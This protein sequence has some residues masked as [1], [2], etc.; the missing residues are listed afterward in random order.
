MTQF[1]AVLKAAIDD[2]GFSQREIARR[3]D[4]L[5]Q[6][7]LSR[8]LGGDLPRKE[9]LDQLCRVFPRHVQ[10]LTAAYLTD[11]IP[12][13]AAKF[14]AVSTVQ[15]EGIGRHEYRVGE[16]PVG[17]ILAKDLLTLGR[18]AMRKPNLAKMLN[19]FASLERG[20]DPHPDY[21]E[22]DEPTRNLREDPRYLSAKEELE[23]RKRP[24]AKPS[25]RSKKRPSDGD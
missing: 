22:P 15:E 25:R 20:E 24:S 23:N 7:S 10:H 17:S 11:L 21:Y 13:A 18:A 3:A 14:V 19:Y 8:F 9:T 1:A 2:S 4:G 6:S 5:E 16:V 12:E